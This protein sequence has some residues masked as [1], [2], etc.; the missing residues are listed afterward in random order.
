MSLD[1]YECA[2]QQAGDALDGIARAEAVAA[3]CRGSGNPA[4]LAWLAEACSLDDSSRLLDLGGGLGGPAAWVSDRYGCEV[5]TI[6]PVTAAAAVARDVFHLTSA[7]ASGAA[8][9][10]A[11][12]SFDVCWLLG[13][14]SVVESATDVLREAARVSS[15]FGAIV[16]VSTSAQMVEAGGS[17]FRTRTQLQTALRVTG[18][19]LSAGPASTALPPPPTWQDHA[20]LVEPEDDERAVARELADGRIE[21]LLVV[22]RHSD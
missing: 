18:W 10:F 14:L 16:Y 22:G 11:D 7:A 3:A 15:T 9:P 20:S 2:A 17:R 19:D 6:D 12:R 1:E 21:S 4:A 13:V 8:L 5:V